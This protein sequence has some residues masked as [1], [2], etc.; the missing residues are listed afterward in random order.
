M[1]P[2]TVASDGPQNQVIQSFEYM[3]KTWA[4]PEARSEQIEMRCCTRQFQSMI[5]TTRLI[6]INHLGYIKGFVYTFVYSL[7]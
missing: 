7:H 5:P 2:M 6:C 1:E 3:K 4:P